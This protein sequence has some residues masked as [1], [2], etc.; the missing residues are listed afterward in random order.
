M[1]SHSFTLTNIVTHADTLLIHN[2]KQ[3]KKKIHRYWAGW[4]DGW[5]CMVSLSFFSSATAASPSFP[6]PCNVHAVQWRWWALIHA[7]TWR[8]VL[9]VV[10][11]VIIS[12][13]I[14]VAVFIENQSFP[15]RCCVHS[16]RIIALIHSSIVL[17]QCDKSVDLHCTDWNARSGNKCE[18]KV[19]QSIKRD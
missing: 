3:K 9:V 5:L 12:S 14:I 13:I 16:G 1:S 19:E 8:S 11:V 18:G 17:L 15:I 4:L 6:S 10:V 2:T 7:F